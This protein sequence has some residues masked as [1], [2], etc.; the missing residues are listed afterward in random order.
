[1][2]VDYGGVLAGP[3]SDRAGVVDVL[4]RVRGHGVRTAMLSNDPGGPGRGADALRALAG[5]ATGDT[6]TGGA[7]RGVVPLFD[8][9]VLSG[10]VGV[11]KPSPASYRLVAQRLG[12]APSECVFVDDLAS[13][14]EG[15][16]AVGMVGVHFHDSAAAL[17]ELS[18]LFESPTPSGRAD[19]R[20]PP[21]G[22]R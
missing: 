17:F 16:V 5:P 20:R 8:H 4:V 21:G 13:N 18:V 11:A 22:T 9:V 14:V 19:R 15:A 1:M 10:D 3:G 6:A 12:L 7:D 2:I